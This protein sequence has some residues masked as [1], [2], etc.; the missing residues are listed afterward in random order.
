[1]ADTSKSANTLSDSECSS[2]TIVGSAGALSGAAIAVGAPLGILHWGQAQQ[3]GGNM[4]RAIGTAIVGAVVLGSLVS[5]L[6]VYFA[7]KKR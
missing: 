4:E 5:F 3:Y 6:S 7:T 1:M 2:R